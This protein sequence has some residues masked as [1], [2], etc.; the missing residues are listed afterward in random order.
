MG[1]DFGGYIDVFVANKSIIVGESVFCCQLDNHF[2]R[3]V[4]TI[5]LLVG[6]K[7]REYLGDA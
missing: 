6:T 2:E 5:E 1:P 7:K 3:Y 4:E